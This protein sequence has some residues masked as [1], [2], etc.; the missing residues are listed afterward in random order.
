MKAF[1]DASIAVDP[2][3]IRLNLVD[4]AAAEAAVM[5]LIASEQPTALFASQNLVTIGAIRALRALGKQHEIALVGFD[6]F[7]L[8]ELLDPAVSVIAQ[9][10]A[11][12]GRI[13]A[14]ELFAR[15]AGDRSP[16]RHHVVETTLIERGSGEI[17][18]PGASPKKA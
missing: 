14:Q 12:M 5:D 9:D 8:A 6:D 2:A 13:A 3:L 7:M 15:L 18:P 17:A 10:P 11:A 4:T 16:S 1:A